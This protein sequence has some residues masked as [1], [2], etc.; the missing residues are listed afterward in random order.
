MATLNEDL[1]HTGTQ[2]D[3][4]S[5]DPGS[6]LTAI[7]VRT[8]MYTEGIAYFTDLVLLTQLLNQRI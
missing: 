8:A 6:G 4:I 2:P 3:P 5:I 7:V 1:F